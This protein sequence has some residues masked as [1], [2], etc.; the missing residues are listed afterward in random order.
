MSVIDNYNFR[1]EQEKC[2]EKIRKRIMS[3]KPIMLAHDV[4]AGK[5]F[6]KENAIK[7]LADLEINRT[8]CIMTKSIESQYVYNGKMVIYMGNVGKNKDFYLFSDGRNNIAISRNDLVQGKYLLSNGLDKETDKKIYQEPK[9]N[10]M[11][12][13]KECR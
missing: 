2:M 4:G 9:K 5:A 12:K 13:N 7:F 1:K 11:K 6:S 10:N 3:S 8:C